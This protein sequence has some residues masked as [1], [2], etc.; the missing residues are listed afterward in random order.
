MLFRSEERILVVL[1]AIEAAGFSLPQFLVTLF[2]P[3]FNQHPTIYYRVAYFLRTRSLNS[4]SPVDLV[5]AIF[6]HPKSRTP[7][8]SPQLP[9]LPRHAW[10]PQECSLAAW[11]SPGTSQE[12]AQA[13]LLDFALQLVLRRV[14]EEAK[15]LLSPEHGLVYSRQALS[16]T[17]LRTF[18]ISSKQELFA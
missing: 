6:E 13:L 11:P 4:P 8:D 14:D 1:R 15:E 16:W 3:G 7:Q 10:L 12:P 9:S 18:S 2:R 5:K 17:M